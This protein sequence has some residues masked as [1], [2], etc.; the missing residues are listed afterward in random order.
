[1]ESEYIALSA[2]CKDSLP[3][4]DLIKE[5]GGCL[6]ISVADSFNIHIKINNDNVGALTLG[7]LE[8]CWMTLRSKHYVIK[9]HWFQT[10]IE[11]CR[12]VL[13]K[14]ESSRQLGNI[15]TKGLGPIAFER[16]QNK[17]MAW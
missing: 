8:P 11:P 6:G 14:I 4:V 9:C 2:S 7:K 16:L 3:T 1:M 12:V 15:S 5:L 13:R 17:L 10:Q